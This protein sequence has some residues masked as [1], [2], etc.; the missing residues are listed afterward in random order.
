VS[1]VLAGL[2]LAAVGSAA[3]AAT[4]SPP[5]SGALGVVEGAID[6]PPEAGLPKAPS[7]PAPSQPDEPAPAP[8]GAIGGPSAGM[9]FVAQRER[10]ALSP[11]PT[12]PEQLT[13]YRWPLPRGRI[14]LP[15]GP[16]HGG[17]RIVDGLPFHDGLDLA[18]VCGDRIV[19]AHAGIALAAGRHY[20]SQMG[21]IGDLGPYFDRLDAKSL[22]VT[23][24]IV[25]VIDDGNGYRSIYAHFGRI[26]VKRG[27]TVQAGQLLGY[28]GRTGN[29]S[30]CHLHYG[31]FSP[32]ASGRFGIDPAIVDH[33]KLPAWEVARVDPLFVLPP[34]TSPSPKPAATLK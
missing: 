32:D 14:T 27:Q 12:G 10:S 29:A 25:V 7:I 26:V 20:D 2:V 33:L 4:A 31:L 11:I 15:F 17:S 18:T 8:I 9:G 21:W 6:R 3:L 23:L 16:W 22:W 1:I 13:G 34:R 30:G 19:A 28:E 5:S 24:P